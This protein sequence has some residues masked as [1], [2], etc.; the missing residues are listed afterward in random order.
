MHYLHFGIR[1][2][3]DLGLV[4][5]PY[6]WMDLIIIDGIPTAIPCLKAPNDVK[7]TH[8]DIANLPT[9]LAADSSKVY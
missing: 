6:L 1:L 7:G 4:F 9:L 8:F 3:H 5:L 2:T